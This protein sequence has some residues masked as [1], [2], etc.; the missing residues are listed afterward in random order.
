M[1]FGRPYILPS[2]S[3][4]GG[5][6]GD[7]PFRNSDQLVPLH[8]ELRRIEISKIKE[9]RAAWSIRQLR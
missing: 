9:P 4:R 7:Q 1:G 6:L 2:V 5:W 3:D 8:L